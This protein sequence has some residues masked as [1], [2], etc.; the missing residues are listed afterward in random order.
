[1][2]FED[3]LFNDLAMTK[4]KSHGDGQIEYSI[5]Q[6]PTRRP[7]YVPEFPGKRRISRIASQYLDCKYKEISRSPRAIV[8]SLQRRGEIS[9]K[10][11]DL[12]AFFGA[13]AYHTDFTLKD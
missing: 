1:M 9:P 7:N 11:R 8:F 3:M 4:V 10:P 5:D 12:A 13:F 2:E 6:A